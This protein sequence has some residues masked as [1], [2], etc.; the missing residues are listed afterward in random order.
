[1]TLIELKTK[2]GFTTEDRGDKLYY[3]YKT[4]NK[5]KAY[6]AYTTLK[7]IPNAR[8]VIE[9]INGGKGVGGYYTSCFVDKT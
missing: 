3:Q 1:M 5:T 8:F 6:E 9:G 2:R 7:T 4:S